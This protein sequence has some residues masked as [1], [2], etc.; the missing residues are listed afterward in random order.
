MV[1]YCLASLLT[2]VPSPGGTWSYTMGTTSVSVGVCPVSGTNCTAPIMTK[3]IGVIGTGLDIC[4]T[5]ST[6]GTYKFTYDV[7]GLSVC[8]DPCVSTVTIDVAEAN[9]EMSGMM[10]DCSDTFKINSGTVSSICCTSDVA[11]NAGVRVDNCQT[12]GTPTNVSST[13]PINAYSGWD[14]VVTSPE[15]FEI[16]SMGLT[17]MSCD[18]TYNEAQVTV[19]GQDGLQDNTFTNITVFQGTCTYVN[20]A[21]YYQCVIEKAISMTSDITDIIPTPTN[22]LDYDLTVTETSPNHLSIRFKILEFQNPC[23]ANGG[24]CLGKV[25]IVPKD[26]T[27]ADTLVH[28]F[29]NTTCALGAN[30]TQTTNADIYLDSATVGLIFN[31]VVGF[32]SVYNISVTFGNI[33]SSTTS[34]NHIVGNPYTLWTILSFATTPPNKFINTG[35]FW[36]NTCRKATITAT[37]DTCPTQI[38]WQD[39]TIT[40]SGAGRIFPVDL[41]TTFLCISTRI[42]CATCS[43]C[44]H[45]CVKENPN[46]ITTWLPGDCNCATKCQSGGCAT[47][48]DPPI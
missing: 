34:Y 27:I 16:F 2:G 32:C 25:W 45:I 7:S 31:P 26:T 3:P 28:G 38:I 36:V 1:S 43:K 46:T 15:C 39:G 11:I 14:I 47:C 37:S 4:V 9:L 29:N 12:N 20:L 42:E 21:Q 33:I 18:G 5:F 44:V 6:P 30:Y 13:V 24:I 17:V 41:D 35:G 23:C 10:S 40:T 8:C 48:G 22:G 19:G